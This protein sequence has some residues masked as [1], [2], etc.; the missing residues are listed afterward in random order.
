YVFSDNQS[1]LN[2][3]HDETEDLSYPPEV[4]L[5]PVNSEEISKILKY[6]NLKKIPVTPCGARTGL[7]GGSLPV[8]GGVALSVERL[9]SIIEIDERN[10][11]A[12]VQP[13]VINQVFRD[14]VELKGL[15]YP[16]DP[17][18]KGSCSLGGNLAENAGGPKAVKYGVTKDYVL[19]LE[20]VLPTGEIIWTGANVLKN[21]TGYDLTALMIGSEGTLGVITTIVFRLIPLPTKD[22]TLFVPF[23][24]FEKACEAVSA[25]FRA[26]IIPSA[27]EFIERDAIDWTL[28]YTDVKLQIND[29]VKA[30]LLVEVDG[31]DMDILYK[32]CERIF[33]VM[34]EFECGEILL[35]DSVSQKN[36]IWKLR[37]SVAEAVKANSIYKEEDTVVPRAEL[38]K[39]LKGV[40][41][42]GKQYGFQSVCYGHAGDGNLHINI[43]KGEMSDEDWN[44]KLTLGIREIFELTKSLGGTLSGEHG[45]GLVQKDYMDIVFCEKALNLQKGIKNL[46]DPYGI[47][48]PG[49]ILK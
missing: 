9:N 47:L 15:F 20:V 8:F 33:E 22:I 39:L 32:D 42:I 3:S 2:Y 4:V 17:A 11:Q 12:T 1:I 38:A 16:P 19:N 26:G 14:A 31:N 27:L 30:H 6:C 46:F 23:S 49:K 43:I 48:N 24:S 36:K 13:G 18:S 25:V 37:R 41:A 10:L 29:D 35:A 44:K 40:K 7:S 45:I 5:K 28:K 21:A 34:Q